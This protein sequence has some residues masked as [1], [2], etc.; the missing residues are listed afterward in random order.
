MDKAFQIGTE[1]KTLAHVLRQ[2]KIGDVVSYQALTESI[3]VNVQSAGRS[4]LASARKLVQ[5]ED[6]MVFDVDRN[7]GLKR[8]DDPSIISLSDKHRDHIRRT[9]RK[10]VKAIACVDYQTLTRENQVRHNTALSMAAFFMQAATDTSAK[11]LSAK[12]ESVGTELPAAKAAIAA[13]G[14]VF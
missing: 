5:R 12:I 13:L 9:A 11:R 2:A 10:T 14:G 6:K 3:G 8:L 4:I 1:T 7:I